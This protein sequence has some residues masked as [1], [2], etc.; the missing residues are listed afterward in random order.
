MS[1][2]MFI[3]DHHQ[4]TTISLH[5]TITSTDVWEINKYSYLAASDRIKVV[6]CWLSNAIILKLFVIQTFG[7]RYHHINVEWRFFSL[8]KKLL[9]YIPIWSELKISPQYTWFFARADLMRQVFQTEVFCH[10][11]QYDIRQ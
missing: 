6:T 3:F 11:R 1:L 2:Q 5:K 4:Q 9:Q 8:L 10:S 7:I